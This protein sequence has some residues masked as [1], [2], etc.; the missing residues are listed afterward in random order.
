MAKKHLYKITYGTDRIQEVLTLDDFNIIKAFVKKVENRMKKFD[1]S[2]DLFQ[3][4][5]YD[6]ANNPLLFITRCLCDASMM[7]YW[8]PY[9]V[10]TKEETL[11]NSFCKYC[12]VVLN[13]EYIKLMSAQGSRRGPFLLVDNNFMRN[14]EE[15]LNF[16]LKI[17][18]TK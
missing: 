11:L 18:G 6:R 7:Y 13:D 2:H 4:I 10:D 1:N 16:I 15:G 14:S 17:W 8:D 5:V 3:D 9:L 12:V